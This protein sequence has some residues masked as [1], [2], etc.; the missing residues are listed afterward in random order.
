MT[1]LRSVLVVVF[2]GC[3]GPARRSCRAFAS[4][5]SRTPTTDFWVGNLYLSPNFPYPHHSNGHHFQQLVVSHSVPKI[6]SAE[7]AFRTNKALSPFTI[8]IHE[9]LAGSTAPILTHWQQNNVQDATAG[10]CVS[11]F[12]DSQHT[13]YRP[14]I[15]IFSLQSK[16][17]FLQFILPFC[18]PI[19]VIFSAWT[20]GLY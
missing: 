3:P 10:Q 19:L 8:T 9:T 5:P 18:L 12:F 13:L 2:R 17:L 16:S 6:R 20:S 14:R 11:A 1:S 15:H 4:A 7:I